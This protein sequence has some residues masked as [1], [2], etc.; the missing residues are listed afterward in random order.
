MMPIDA[1]ISDTSRAIQHDPSMDWP[2]TVK[3]QLCWR[4]KAGRARIA[5]HIISADAFFG[6]GAYG[7]PLDGSALIS[8]IERMRKAGPPKLGNAS[9]KEANG[10]HPRG[11]NNGFSKLSEEN[12]IEILS[13]F[14]AGETAK[15]L[16]REFCITP[17]H[18]NDLYR[19]KAWPHLN[20]SDFKNRPILHRRKKKNL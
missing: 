11:Q 8:L 3:I 7:A 2:E 12:V 13:R 4:D 14:D 9:H 18:V 16:A 19:G 17:L 6:R 10:T 5:T 15:S 20:R 1:P